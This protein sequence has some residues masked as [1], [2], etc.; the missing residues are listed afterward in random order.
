MKD[1]TLV[2]HAHSFHFSGLIGRSWAMLFAAAGYRVCLYDVSEEQLTSALS[3]IKENL[4][5]LE[6]VGL[7][8]GTLS[9][10]EQFERISVCSDMQKA[11]AGAMYVQV[12]W[13]LAC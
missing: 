5:M 6:K 3:V 2:V 12:R 7:L 10:D 11:V 4:V 8:R 1:L 13:A 9:V